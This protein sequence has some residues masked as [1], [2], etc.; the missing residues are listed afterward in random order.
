MRMQEA[1]WQRRL[2][3]VVVAAVAG[4]RLLLLLRGRVFI[5]LIR[6][7]CGRAILQRGQNSG[8]LAANPG[9]DSA[10]G[11]AR[12]AAAGVVPRRCRQGVADGYLLERRS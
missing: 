3:T 9:T 6:P 7:S 5:H 2:R 8:A 11:G 10:G 1:R 12:A 4:W